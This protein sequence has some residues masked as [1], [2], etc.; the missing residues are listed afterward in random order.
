VSVLVFDNVFDVI[1]KDVD[2][3]EFTPINYNECFER[4][5]T[6]LLDAVGEGINLLD[7]NASS[8]RFFGYD[9]TFLIIAVTD[10]GENASRKFN[11]RT[12]MDRVREVQKTDRWTI[13]FLVPPGHKHTIEKLGV[14]P[15]NI[16]E[17]EGTIRGVQTYAKNSISS[18]ANYVSTR[19][20]GGT[21]TQSFHTDLSGLTSNQ[22]KK[23]LDD[24]S[25][26]VRVIAVDKEMEI[27][28]FV[29]KKMNAPY[30]AGSAFYQLT[31]DE[32]KIQD[33]K[34]LL[35]MEKG[36]RA[37]YGGPDARQVLGI[38]EGTL[39]VKPGNH[40]NW[41]VFVQSNSNNRKLVRGTKVLVKV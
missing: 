4:N 20:V 12:F 30:V 11:E 27:R 35:V 37:V 17:W 7:K 28:D 18:V 26:K 23:Q 24:I 33:Y 19:S 13:T 34:Q 16:A 14:Y 9:N 41:D 29:E 21:Y 3:N 15:G 8:A 32:K 2:A 39:K 5:S 22:V 40:A 1:R 38:P 31:K 10:G 25:H 6:A 36:K